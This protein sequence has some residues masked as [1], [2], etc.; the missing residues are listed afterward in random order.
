MTRAGELLAEAFQAQSIVFN[1]AKTGWDDGIA[2][3]YT[4]G[5][6]GRSKGAMISHGN[7]ATNA[8]TLAQAWRYPPAG[9]ADACAADLSYARVVR[10][11]EHA[12]GRGR[13]DVLR[14]SSTGMIC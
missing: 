3:L 4:S 8:L 14:S 13:I 5:T 1:D 2:L 12:A 10:G 7:L 9:C 6:T 11:D